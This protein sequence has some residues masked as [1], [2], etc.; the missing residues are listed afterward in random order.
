MSACELWDWACAHTPG[1]AARFAPHYAAYHH[2]RS[3]GWLPLP[4]LLYGADYALYA[5]HPGLCHSDYAVTVMVQH[6]DCSSSRGGGDTC[7]SGSGSGS[8]GGDGSESPGAAPG[9]APASNTRLAWLDAHI[10]QRLARQVLKRLLLLYIVV[11]AGVTLSVPDCL[12][13]LSVREV[14]LQ[15]W[16]PSAHREDG[17]Q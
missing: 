13:Q 5:L 9:G 11:P 1:G 2:L 16:V 6:T 15:R 7:G 3:K 12:A 8:G 10:M 14:L 4:G 17:R